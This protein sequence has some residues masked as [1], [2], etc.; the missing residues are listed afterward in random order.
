MTVWPRSTRPTSSMTRIAGEGGVIVV[1]AP[2]QLVAWATLADGRATVDVH[3]ARRGTGSAWRCL[4]G[5]RL[6]LERRSARSAPGVTKCG[7]GCTSPVRGCRLPRPPHTRGSRDAAGGCTA[8]VSHPPEITIRRMR[9]RCRGQLPADRDA[10]N[11]WPGASRRSSRGVSPRARARI[12]RTGP[13]VSH[14]TGRSWWGRRFVRITRVRTRAGCSSL[15]RRR[16]IGIGGLLALCSS[17][18]SP[19]T[20]PPGDGWSGCRR[21]HAPAHSRCTSGSGCGCDGP[22]PRGQRTWARPIR[23]QATG[24][25]PATLRCRPCCRRGRR[26]WAV[27]EV[28]APCETI[29]MWCRSRPRSPSRR[30]CCRRLMIA[31]TP[32]APRSGCHRGM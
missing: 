7:H 14:S 24:H 27:L 6:R 3:P 12:V 21:I 17:R 13:S 18:H 32:A 5:P 28:A 29:A 11:E 23:R 19:R 20:T 15:R 31:V 25:R 26:G 1:E 16:R 10:F 22:T 4:P 2:D 8:D 9:R 30:G